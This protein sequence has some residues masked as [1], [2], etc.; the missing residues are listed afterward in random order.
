MHRVVE[1]WGIKLLK[2]PL[3]LLVIADC[4]LVLRG[5]FDNRLVA[6]FSIIGAFGVG[7][8]TSPIMFC[9]LYFFYKKSRRLQYDLPVGQ[10][11][12]LDTIQ[13]LFDASLRP[14][15][16][17]A[18]NKLSKAVEEVCKRVED[19]SGA[20]SEMMSFEAFCKSNAFN[21][22]LYN[23]FPLTAYKLW[24]RHVKQHLHEIESKK[25]SNKKYMESINFDED[26]TVNEQ[27][28]LLTT[29]G[30]VDVCL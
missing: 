30:S 14:N 25:G 13:I 18:A 23:R 16:K 9:V 1:E 15:R 7:L 4:V 20:E 6:I 10:R 22:S 29:R 5:T 17:E 3:A 12:V 19:A 11:M 26:N 27:M 8:V 28:A 24:T 21:T 2:V